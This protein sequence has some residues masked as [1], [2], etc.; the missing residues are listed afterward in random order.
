ML[1]SLE[2]QPFDPTIGFASAKRTYLRQE[3]GEYENREE[4]AARVAAGN[5]LLDKSNRDDFQQ[6]K[7]EVKELQSQ[8]LSGKREAILD[9]RIEVQYPDVAKEMVRVF[10]ATRTGRALHAGRHLQ[11]SDTELHNR[12]QELVTNCS[13]AALRAQVLYL[14]LNGSG[15]ASLYDNDTITTDWSKQPDL[16]LVLEEDHDD[17]GNDVSGSAWRESFL[18]PQEASMQALQ[19]GKEP[20]GSCQNPE[21]CSCGNPPSD[22]VEYFKVPDSREG[23][24]EA[25]QLLEDA[26]YRRTK[27]KAAPEA[28]F[29]DFSDVRPYGSPIGGM[30]DRPASGPVPLM[31]GLAEV[32]S[33]QDSDQD[34]WELAMKVDHELAAIVAVGGVRRAARLAL[35]YWKDEGIFDFIEFKRKLRNRDSFGRSKY[36]SSN[37]SVAID[38]E[39]RDRVAKVRK[40][41][42]DAG[43]SFPDFAEKG[44]IG[45]IKNRQTYKRNPGVTYLVGENGKEKEITEERYQTLKDAEGTTPGLEDATRNAPRP[46]EGAVYDKLTRERL[47]RHEVDTSGLTDTDLRA[48]NVYFASTACAF[49]DESGEPGFINV[50]RLDDNYTGLDELIHLLEENPDEAIGYDEFSLTDDAVEQTKELARAAEEKDYPFLVNPCAEINLFF[51][52]G[53]CVIGSIAPA[54]IVRNYDE[55]GE[56]S[57]DQ[58]A[59]AM[60]Q[61]ARMEA[62]FLIRSNQLAAFFKGEVDRTQ[63]IG[64]G[65]CD[66]HMVYLAQFGLSFHEVV[67]EEV[68]EYLTTPPEERPPKTTRHWSK[69]QYDAI[70]F[71]QLMAETSRAVRD[72]ADKYSDELGVN[73]PHTST[74]VAPNGTTGKLDNLCEGAHLPSMRYYLR[75]T[76]FS[77]DDPLVEE[78]EEAGYP[79]KEL[80]QYQGSTIVGFPTMPLIMRVAKN[81]GLEDK[82][83]TASEASPEEHYRWVKLMETQW[84]QGDFSHPGNQVSYT[85]NFDPDEVDFADFDK[86]IRGGQ[87]EVRTTSFM[88]ERETSV[89]P[90]GIVEEITGEPVESDSPYEYLPNQQVPEEVFAAIKDRISEDKEEDVNREHLEC[91]GGACPIVFND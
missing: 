43:L 88:V 5:V 23:W 27:G 18:T 37:N 12:V 2:T 13:T 56:L 77:S 62:R 21:E 25:V 1:Q 85:L 67:D 19:Y 17:Y 89:D 9:G 49:Y 28:I 60:E 6:L 57:T 52:G 38:D 35:K 14:L 84:L 55:V 4:M 29:L 87:F 65:F 69:K 76:Q 72:E 15:C 16:Y 73:R 11:H 33:L 70:L 61:D 59:A 79:T 68:Y 83:V 82:V 63:R 32:A 3:D 40:R 75:N 54:N 58:L 34:P 51:L 44:T 64:V 81:L 39:F 47:A 7:E 31:A 66:P 8:L 86:A 22:C 46:I 24:A 45:Y 50:D 10:D 74:M 36:W 91:E 80:N 30:Q 41:L 26:T 71:W 78:Y 42:E 20:T 90:H 53:Y 48:A